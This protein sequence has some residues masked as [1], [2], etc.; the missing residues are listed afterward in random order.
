MT[1]AI[2]YKCRN[3]SNCS[4]F[5]RVYESLYKNYY[6]ELYFVFEGHIYHYDD[7]P[8]HK[9]G[10]NQYYWDFLRLFKDLGLKKLDFDYEVIKYKDK[11]T[12]FDSLTKNK[13]EYYTGMIKG[14]K[15]IEEFEKYETPINI[16]YNKEIGYY[17]DVFNVKFNNRH[18]DYLLY[19]RTKKEFLDVLAN[20]GALFSTIKFFFSL[21]FSFYSRNFD[22]YKII[23][24]L[25]NP[26]HEEE[27]IKI[28]STSNKKEENYKF[29]NNTNNLDKLIEKE[30]DKNKI[31]SKIYESNI[32]G[33]DSEENEITN[34]EKIN[35]NN[36]DL[37]K[38]HFYD[39]L[40]N[41]IYSN[42]C[43]RKY[44]QE[45]INNVNNIA[46]KYLSVDYLLYNQIKLENLFKDYK[47]NNPALNDVQNN[48]LI[49]KLKNT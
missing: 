19:K 42:C 48:K 16:K 26:V 47:W 3:D 22:N 31:E 4:S 27:E 1:F 9:E 38:L 8:V 18:E 25:L 35:N 23:E 6:F 2:A 44:N 46:Y 21:F 13:K 30:S 36:N 49:I 29:T 39:Y 12:L 37:K 14:D 15:Y 24:N 11:R 28:N 40:F 10:T 33:E 5:K 20:I 32:N 45:I 41:N 34:N 17:I 43:K 7:S